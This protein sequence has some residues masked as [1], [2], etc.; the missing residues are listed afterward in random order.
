M[1]DTSDPEL[2]RAQFESFGKQMPLLYLILVLN[3]AAITVEFFRPNRIWM[4]TIA[5]LVICGVALL[6][7]WWWWRQSGSSRFSDADITRTLRRTC[8]LAVVLTLAFDAWSMT[9]Y[10]SGDGYARA[11]LSFFLA[12]T[13][14]ST[15]F[16][17]MTIRAAVM[18][19]A[20][21]S[22]AC[23][24]IYFS[25]VDDGQMLVEALVLCF[26]GLGMMVVTNR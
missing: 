25:L 3:A 17:L 13:Q 7:G 19:V 20:A 14:V 24:V 16:C 6:R 23:F 10:P 8:N 22:T 12:L 26:V 2:A 15:V 4:S 21:T 1:L 11:H 18:R 5:P 9:I